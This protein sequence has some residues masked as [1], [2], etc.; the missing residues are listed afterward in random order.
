MQHS[1]YLALRLNTKFAFSSPDFAS[2][3][4]FLRHNCKHLKSYF[5]SKFH[6]R[7]WNLRHK[8]FIDKPMR[9]DLNLLHHILS[10]PDKY[11]WSIP[12]RHL[13]P[14]DYDARFK[15]DA[16][17]TGCSGFSVRLRFWFFLPWPPK[18]LPALSTRNPNPPTSFPSTALNIP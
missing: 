10:H 18:S 6:K 13:I 12:I 15:G 16:C 14:T 4:Q 17:L 8:F 7:I 9:Q 2:F 1:V 11:S 3:M 5:T